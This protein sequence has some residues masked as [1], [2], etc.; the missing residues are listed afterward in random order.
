MPFPLLCCG[1]LGPP[2]SMGSAITSRKF[3]KLDRAGSEKH[4]IDV[5]PDFRRKPHEREGFERFLCRFA[6][7]VQIRECCFRLLSRT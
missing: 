3:W 5:V 7:I 4:A 2:S 6:M 1:A